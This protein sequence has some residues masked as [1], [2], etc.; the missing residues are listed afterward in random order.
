MRLRRVLIMIQCRLVP[1]FIITTPFVAS[2]FG[3][4][5]ARRGRIPRSGAVSEEQRS[6]NREATQPFGRPVFL[7][8]ASLLT[9]PLKGMAVPPAPSVPRAPRRKR[10]RSYE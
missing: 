4:G 2:I 1:H 3:S 5:E 8:Q 9:P 7:A 6:Q 10:G